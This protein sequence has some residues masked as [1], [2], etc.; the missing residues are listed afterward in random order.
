MPPPYADNLLLEHPTA[1]RPSPSPPP[2]LGSIKWQEL[3]L[4]GSL[5]SEMIMPCICANPADPC[6]SHSMRKSG[7]MEQSF[8]ERRQVKNV[9]RRPG[10]VTH[11]CNPSPLEGRG[12]QIT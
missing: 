11:A 9:T 6:W 4:Q 10:A 3:F 1:V 12:G 8:I 5:N 7:I 2:T